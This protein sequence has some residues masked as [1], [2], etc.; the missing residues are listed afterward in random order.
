MIDTLT[1]FALEGQ[2]H[3]AL[4]SHRVRDR[5]YRAL[6]RRDWP[7][8]ARRI[9]QDLL[10]EIEKPRSLEWLM[11]YYKLTPTEYR[12]VTLMAEG[13]SVNEIAERTNTAVYT[14]RTHVRNI[15]GKCQVNHLAG[16]MATVLR[17]PT[18]IRTF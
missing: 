8:E 4:P 16:L 6:L 14:V 15:Y 11:D 5:A 9:L 17:G 12:V 3:E 18:P 1:Q 7:V 2:P 10:T 13:L